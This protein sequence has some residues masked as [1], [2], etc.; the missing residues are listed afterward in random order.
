MGLLHQVLYDFG[1]VSVE[2]HED[3]G[4]LTFSKR[5]ENVYNKIKNR[6]PN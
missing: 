3:P 5:R 1:L 4:L 6:P 2:M